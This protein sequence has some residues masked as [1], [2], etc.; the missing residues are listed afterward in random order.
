MARY[1]RY[2]AVQVG[3]LSQGASVVKIREMGPKNRFTSLDTSV[4]ASEVASSAEG[5]RLTNMYSLSDKIYLMKFS[6][7]ESERQSEERAR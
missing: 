1:R 5:L 3:G 4:M 6:I 2:T 7:P